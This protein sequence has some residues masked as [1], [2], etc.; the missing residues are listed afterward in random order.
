M[1]RSVARLLPRPLARPHVFGGL[2]SSRGLSTSPLR[3]ESSV[4]SPDELTESQRAVLGCPEYTDKMAETWKAS[5][6]FI[7]GEVLKIQ[8]HPVMESWEHPY[9]ARLAEIATSQGGKVLELGFGMSISATYIQ[10]HPIAEHW[11][12]EANE[13]VAERAREWSSTTAKS[14]VVINEGFS[15]DVSPGLADGSFDG[16]LYDTYPIQAGKANLHQRDFFSEAARLLKPGGVFT[17]FCNEDLDVSDEEKAILDAHGFDVTT[18][19]VDVPT[20][21]DCQYWRAKTIVAPICI[22]R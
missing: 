15:W 11:V 16:I 7:D 17:Y 8:G 2:V 3:E 22:K 21:D 19:Q 9:M 20:P 5:P 12:I 14:K 1:L 13:Q 6:I 4:P 18:E 10:S